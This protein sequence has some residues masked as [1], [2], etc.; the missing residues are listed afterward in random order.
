MKNSLISPDGILSKERKMKI[1]HTEN[2]E[3]CVILLLLGFRS[4]PF[5]SKIIGR[6]AR[7]KCT[8]LDNDIT[9]R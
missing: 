1:K 5:I 9:F 2:G 6:F 4:L 3:V 7:M 8:R